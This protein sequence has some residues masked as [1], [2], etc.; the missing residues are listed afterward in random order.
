MSKKMHKNC[1]Y[2]KVT[3][4]HVQNPCCERLLMKYVQSLLNPYA[5]IQSQDSASVN[6]ALSCCDWWHSQLSLNL[7]IVFISYCY[8]HMMLYQAYCSVI[9]DRLIHIASCAVDLLSW[10]FN[11][12]LT[13]DWCTTLFLMNCCI[14]A[15][16]G[17]PAVLWYGWN[18][19]C[20]CCLWRKSVRLIDAMES[21]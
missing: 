8:R 16:Y 6:S 14:E 17:M 1:L 3:R 12:D 20:D 4:I 19:C 10:A 7:Y 9:C 13:G 5:V 21:L 18:D 15:V 2:Y 11:V